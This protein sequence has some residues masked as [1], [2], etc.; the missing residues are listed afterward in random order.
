MIRRCIALL[1]MAIMLTATAGLAI[2][3]DKEGKEGKKS[4]SYEGVYLA[5]EKQQKIESIMREFDNATE[6]QRQDLYSKQ[7]Q[8]KA[9]SGSSDIDRK[10][11][12]E[13]TDEIAK[14]EMDLV[15]KY[16]AAIDRI[17]SELGPDCADYACKRGH[18][19]YGGYMPSMI[20]P[21]LLDGQPVFVRPSDKKK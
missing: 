2:A 14:L 20:T 9:V 3:G 12:A 8:L 19:H 18:Y 17:R 1:A 13:L 15:K 6:Q 16:R 5:P 7:L 4:K 21:D 10:W 11:L